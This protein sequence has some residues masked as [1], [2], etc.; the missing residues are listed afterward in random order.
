MLAALQMLVYTQCQLMADR[1]MNVHK[2]VNT[3][4]GKEVIKRKADKYGEELPTEHLLGEDFG[5]RNKKVSKNVRAADTVMNTALTSKKSCKTNDYN[6]PA[7]MN[8][9]A[10]G[11][12]GER[13]TQPSGGAVPNMER[14]ADQSAELLF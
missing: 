4:M 7:T 5:E 14:T 9:T 10:H 6:R 12:P 8:R 1:V 13:G 2:V 11:F 3:P